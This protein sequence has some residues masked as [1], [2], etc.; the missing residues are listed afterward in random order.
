MGAKL[1]LRCPHVSDQ[2]CGMQFFRPAG[3][4]WLHAWVLQSNHELVTFAH[5]PP[6]FREYLLCSGHVRR[7]PETNLSDTRQPALSH[8]CQTHSMVLSDSCHTSASAFNLLSLSYWPFTPVLK[9]YLKY[10]SDSLGIQS[11]WMRE[12]EIYGIS[13]QSKQAYVY[14]H[15]SGFHKGSPKLENYG[16]ILTSIAAMRYLN[17]SRISEL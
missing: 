5:L 12:F 2:T 15:N 8:N 10:T 13:G 9:A 11:S 17:A 1:H 16:V 6:S 7:L 3:L 4:L 14:T